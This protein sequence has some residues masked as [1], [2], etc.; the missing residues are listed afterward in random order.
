[1]NIEETKSRAREGTDVCIL[2]PLRM[3]FMQM[4]CLL[5]FL[6][7]IKIVYLCVS[8]DCASHLCWVSLA[9]Y[10]KWTHYHDYSDL[11]ETIER[12]IGGSRQRGARPQLTA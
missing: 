3:C 6:Q 11:E 12:L 9:D 1:M 10:L 8:E 5:P 7:Y 2:V 4:V